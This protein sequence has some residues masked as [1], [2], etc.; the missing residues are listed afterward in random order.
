VMAQ[1]QCS[2]GP[3]CLSRREPEGA[4]SEENVN[5]VSEKRN[6]RL[7]CEN[8][9]EAI[10]SISTNSRCRRR[11]MS[12]FCLIFQRIAAIRRSN[13]KHLRKQKS[14]ENHVKWRC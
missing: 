14:D 7:T 3:C 12:Y 6:Y 9:L 10:C 13:R 1:S 8:G 2:R 11:N 5:C 4:I